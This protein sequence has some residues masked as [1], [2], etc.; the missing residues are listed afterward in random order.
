MAPEGHAGVEVRA[1]RTGI[2]GV[3]PGDVVVEAFG[4]ELDAAFQHAIARKA[5]PTVWLNLEYLTAEPFAERNHGLRSPVMLGPAAG[6]YKCFFYPG[7]TAGT[8]GLPRDADLAQRQ[9]AFDPR[10]WLA[11]HRI[12]HDHARRISLFCYEPAG[13]A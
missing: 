11:S 12:P 4:C 7:F 8:G 9:A 5:K 1:W 13:L 10:A 6:L 3:E 2:E